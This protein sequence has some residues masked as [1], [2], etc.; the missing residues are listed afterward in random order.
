MGLF[1]IN[2]RSRVEKRAA[3]YRFFAQKITDICGFTVVDGYSFFF[4]YLIL[5]FGA[6]FRV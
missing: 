2:K 6:V 5:I 4:I 1:S 3:V